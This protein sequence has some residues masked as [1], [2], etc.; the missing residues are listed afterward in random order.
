MA[1]RNSLFY[2]KKYPMIVVYIKKIIVSQEASWRHEW[3]TVLKGLGMWTYWTD[4]LCEARIFSRGL[5]GN[6]KKHTI[7]R[8]LQGSLE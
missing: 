7:Q 2:N 4:I 3:P 8:G 6:F 5:M 1:R